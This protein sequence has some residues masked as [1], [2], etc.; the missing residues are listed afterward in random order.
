MTATIK[1]KGMTISR[2]ELEDVISRAETRKQ[3]RESGE[4]SG[5]RNQRNALI[6]ELV[7]ASTLQQYPECKCEE[8]GLRAGMSIVDAIDLGAGCTASDTHW[9]E[10]DGVREWVSSPGKGFVCPRL[11]KVRRIYGR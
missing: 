8:R 4:S 9:E 11:D 3:Q 10:R 6:S 1:L 7:L 5:N 2:S